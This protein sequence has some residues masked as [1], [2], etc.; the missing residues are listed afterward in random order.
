MAEPNDGFDAERVRRLA[1]EKCDGILSEEGIDELSQLLASSAHARDEY[2]QIIAIHAQLQWELGEEPTREGPPAQDPI[3]GVAVAANVDGRHSRA[4]RSSSWLLGLAA[5]LLV[6]AFAALLAWRRGDDQRPPVAAA[7]EQRANSV[8]GTLTEL[9]PQSNW[10]VGRAGGNNIGSL[11]QGDTIYLDAGAAELRLITKTVA[12]LESPLVMQLVSVDRVRVIR[13]NIKVDVAKGAEGFS[14]ETASAEVI[15]LGTEFAVNVKDGNTDV[16]VYDGQVDLKVAATDVSQQDSDRITKRF[17]AGEAV[18]VTNDGTLS[19]IVDVRRTRFGAEGGE[20]RAN[21]VIMAVR[22][23]YDRDDFWSF[24][25]IVP[26]G[27]NEDARA[28]VDR[29]FHEWNGYTSEGMP[30]Y[31]V[32]ADYVKTFNDDKV[33][34]DLVI[35]VT[36]SRPATLYVLLDPRVL[37]PPWLLESFENT[38]DIVGLDEAPYYPDKP[39]HITNGEPQVGAGNGINRVFKIWKREVRNGGVVSLG[40]NGRRAD[41]P[42]GLPLGEIKANMYAIVAVPLAK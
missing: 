32:G 21:Q 5:C 19:R 18:H 35:D 2:W 42:Q 28:F 9:V 8:L 1:Q 22:D 16:V 23:N 14:V 36:L 17:R 29:P 7:D 25:E 4:F 15:D 33:T 27:M 13:G 30:S 12:V 6:A 38:G 37:P 39:E 10:S 31:L 40:P 3:L 41:D 34:E 20:S 11:Q 24:Y 26:G